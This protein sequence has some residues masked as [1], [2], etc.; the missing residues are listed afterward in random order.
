MA[1]EPVYY[2]DATNEDIW[3]DMKLINSKK[4]WFFGDWP[5]VKSFLDAAETFLDCPDK[6][7]DLVEAI[8]A[9]K[10]IHLTHYR[11]WVEALILALEE[12][13]KTKGKK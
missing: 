1:R 8:K 12:R 7:A 13:I 11:W 2:K 5:V 9:V 4:P 6:S 10:D 3:H